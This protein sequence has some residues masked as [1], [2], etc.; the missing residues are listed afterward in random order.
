MPL[1]WLH[2]KI[3]IVTNFEKTCEKIRKKNIQYL[4]KE[5]KHTT[6]EDKFL[7]NHCILM[8]DVTCVAMSEAI[9]NVCA[10]II[11][12]VILFHTFS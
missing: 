11:N 3:K 5:C 7:F 1:C 6:K 9:T 2:L 12:N 10:F 4:E 8:G